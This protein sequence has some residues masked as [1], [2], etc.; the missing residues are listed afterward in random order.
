MVD[1]V[2]LK[3]FAKGKIAAFGIFIVDNDNLLGSGIAVG[4]VYILLSVFGDGHTGGTDIGFAGIDRRNDGIE[5]H[6]FNGHFHAQFITD[7]LHDIHVDTGDFTVIDIFIRRK[8]RI[9]GNNQFALTL[10]ILLF[11]GHGTLFLIG[12]DIVGDDFMN[13]AVFLQLGQCLI[14]LIQ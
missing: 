6:V 5:F 2:L 1:K 11:I 10:H 12:T 8:F 14:D 7:G 9:R 13:R 3:L 4:K